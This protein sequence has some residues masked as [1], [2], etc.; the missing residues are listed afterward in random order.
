MHA[1]KPQ[2]MYQRTRIPM[3]IIDEI[4]QAI[5]DVLTTEAEQAGRASG[6]V[7][8]QSKFDGA[9]LAQALAFRYLSDSDATTDDL[10]QTAATLGVPIPG[11]A[12]VQRCN[13][14]AATCLQ[15]ALG[16]AVQRVLAVDPTTDRA[17]AGRLRGR[18]RSG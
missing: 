17:H 11:S 12:M 3:P 10:A 13:K 9:A 2:Q 8:R 14:A 4:A 15:M 18:G 6:F 7:R 1:S 16:T 5:Q